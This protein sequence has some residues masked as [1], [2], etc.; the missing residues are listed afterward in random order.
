[1]MRLKKKESSSSMLVGASADL[2]L[3]R[4]TFGLSRRRG[5]NDL[6]KQHWNIYITICKTVSGSLMLEKEMAA[7]SNILAWRNPW[8]EEPGGLLS[9][10]SHRVGHD[11]SDLAAAAAA[12]ALFVVTRHQKRRRY[13][14]TEFT[15]CR[16]A[17]TRKLQRNNKTQFHAKLWWN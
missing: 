1:M 14:S 10:G 5:R 6:R 13:P 8:T 7:H 12:E 15:Y 16:I 17:K 3:N 2:T 9:M 11:W 4:K